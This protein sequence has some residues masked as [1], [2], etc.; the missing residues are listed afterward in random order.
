MTKH[1]ELPFD[2]S[3]QVEDLPPD[4]LER[5]EHARFLTSFLVDKGTNGNYVLNLDAQWG[6]GK[7]WFIRR[8][9]KEISAIHPTVYIDAWKN[10]H[11]GDPFLTVVSE[12]KSALASK[13][14]FSFLEHNVLKGTWRLM[15]S[16][17]PEVTKYIIKSKLGI[18]AKDLNLDGEADLGSKIVDELLKSHQ[19][20]N[21]SADSFKKSIFEWLEAVIETN[22]GKYE[23]PLF[24]FIDELDRCRPNY[25]IEMLETIKHLFDI[26]KVVFIVST[27]KEQLI[28][29]ICS[30]Y[31]SGFDARSYLDRFFMRSVTLKKRTLFE[32]LKNK[33]NNSTTFERVLNKHEIIIHDSHTPKFATLLEILTVVADGFSMDLRTTNLWFERLESIYSHTN[34]NIEILSLSFILAV[35]TRHNSYYKEIAFGRNTFSDTSGNSINKI[36]KEDKSLLIQTSIK[37]IAMQNSLQFSPPVIDH[38]FIDKLTPTQLLNIIFLKIDSRGALNSRG[39]IDN[40]L[41]EMHDKKSEYGALNKITINSGFSQIRINQASNIYFEK[42]FEENKIDFKE[43]HS[44]CELAVLIE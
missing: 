23:Y 24:I 1:L 40:M 4:A 13:T 32:F 43:Y 33:L 20:A 30:V 26:N 5:S 19:E 6:A 15:K 11:S 10:D 9:M 39:N 17:A 38:L 31:G 29:S 3:E 44:L 25:A 37:D 16:I 14:E 42:F 35:Y 41:R 8:W 12:I 22:E 18:D 21:S 2:W 28:H 27:D 36:F 34:K 7:T